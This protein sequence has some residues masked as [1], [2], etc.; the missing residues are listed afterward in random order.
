[1]AKKRTNVLAI[2]GL[3]SGKT[4]SL[5]IPNILEMDSSIIVSDPDNEVLMSM[6]PLLMK[7]GY[8]IKTL[9]LGS[10]EYSHHY[11]PLKYVY[12]INGEYSEEKTSII[13]T[14]Y[15]NEVF[16]YTGLEIFY[17]NIIRGMLNAGIG[18][19]AEL[20]PEEERN[21]E[22]LSKLFRQ[23]IYA[24]NVEEVLK[25]ISGRNPGAK[26]KDILAKMSQ[27]SGDMLNRALQALI[28]SLEGLVDDEEI[29][30]LLMIEPFSESSSIT[31]STNI[32]IES[33][34]YKRTALFINTDVDKPVYRWINVTLISQCY[35]I[36]GDAAELAKNKYYIEHNGYPISGMFDTE[37]TAEIWKNMYSKAYVTTDNGI[38]CLRSDKGC[39]TYVCNKEVGEKKIS[40]FREAKIT[41]QQDRKLPMPV[42]VILKDLDHI[43]AIPLLEENMASGRYIGMNTILTARSYRQLAELYPNTVEKII[44]HCKFVMYFGYTDEE[45]K[46]YILKLIKDNTVQEMQEL[47]PEQLPDTMNIIID[48]RTEPYTVRYDYKYDITQ[49]RNYPIYIKHIHPEKTIAHG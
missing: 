41:M 17:V 49:H 5:I 43:G 39:I 11:N 3:H 31:Q 24:K 22:G 42:K 47:I 38:A 45:S 32:D 46:E 14:A 36:L 40:E 27:I 15:I 10:P 44:H 13:A 4:E 8:A 21:L 34:G 33:I 26:S 7:I 28:T 20:A 16:P 12:D 1:M 29:A 6:G 18:Y 30:D 2:G 25:D 9:T 37:D 48:M 23:W 35:D 19:L